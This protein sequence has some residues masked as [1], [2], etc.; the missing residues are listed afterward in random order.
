MKAG[1]L[2][3]AAGSEAGERRSERGDTAY[4]PR[5]PRGGAF[6]HRLTNTMGS[7]HGNNQPVLSLRPL[8]SLR[9]KHQSR[10]G[11]FS[12]DWGDA[13]YTIYTFYTAKICLGPRSGCFWAGA[14]TG[15]AKTDKWGRRPRNHLENNRNENRYL[16]IVIF[17]FRRYFTIDDK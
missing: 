13:F 5:V 7:A 12:V 4:S 15:A 17:G 6:G 11:S 10:L 14:E 3:V 1:S 16:L 9:L 2:R 8:R